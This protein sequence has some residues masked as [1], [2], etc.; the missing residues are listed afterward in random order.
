MPQ[1][2]CRKGYSSIHIFKF[3]RHYCILHYCSYDFEYISAWIQIVQ[4]DLLRVHLQFSTCILFWS[5]WCSEYYNCLVS[6][7]EWIVK[8]NSNG[9]Q[10]CTCKVF[11]GISNGWIIDTM[12]PSI[13][14]SIK[15]SIVVS[16]VCSIEHIIVCSNSIETETYYYLAKTSTLSWWWD[17]GRQWQYSRYRNI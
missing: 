5:R 16:F 17:F 6:G 2:W 13:E 15:G 3:N 4:I 12:I 8:V 1:C 11:V 7:T 14:C 9:S 10:S